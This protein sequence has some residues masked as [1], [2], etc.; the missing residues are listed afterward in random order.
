MNKDEQTVPQTTLNGPTDDGVT[1][2]TDLD[3][4]KDIV[5]TP[6]DDSKPI[7]SEV[8]GID[9]VAADSVTFHIRLEGQLN[10]LKMT[11]VEKMLQFLQ[12]NSSLAAGLMV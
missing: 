1:E 6:G 10:V 7:V 5:P 9:D 3:Q 4:H 2:N 8:N 12:L 11:V